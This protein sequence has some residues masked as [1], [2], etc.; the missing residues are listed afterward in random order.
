MLTS[1]ETEKTERSRFVGEGV[2]FGTRW[3]KMSLDIS[4]RLCYW[5]QMFAVSP[6]F[7]D[8]RINRRT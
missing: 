4:D 8:V 2:Q 5:S 1:T 3:V 6:H 7:V